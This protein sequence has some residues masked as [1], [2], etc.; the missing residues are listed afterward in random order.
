MQERWKPSEIGLEHFGFAFEQVLRRSSSGVAVHGMVPIGMPRIRPELA[1]STF[2]LFRRNPKSGKI[3]G[4]CG[5]GCIVGR[6][7]KEN[8]FRHYY[9]VT[10]YH[11]SHQ[12]G[13]TIIRL[14]TRDGDTRFLE[15]ETEDW[16]FVPNGDDLSAVDLTDDWKEGDQFAVQMEGIFVTDEVIRRFEINPGEDVLMIG[17]FT[18]HHGGKRNKPVVRSGN[19]AMT[20]DPNALVKQPNGALRPSHLVDMRSRTGFSGSPVLMYRTLANALTNIGLYNTPLLED[21]SGY[22]GG[23]GSHTAFATRKDWFVG[24]LGIHCGQF[25]DVAKI[26]KSPPEDDSERIGDP[27]SEGDEIYIQSGMTIVVPASRI[28]E[29]LD[30]EVFHMV[31]QK[32]DARRAGYVQN[33]NPEVEGEGALPSSDENPTHREDFN[34]LLSEAVREREPKD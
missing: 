14:N 24:L 29:L 7:T 31:R 20:A 28:S 27:I 2:Y 8:Q 3:E 5:T 23:H 16:H 10:N 19:L 12:L 26:R 1:D 30:L 6:D 9:G 21:K 17:M 32:R 22:S 15:Y 18:S 34:S 4:P 11:V 25:W 13:A 33:P